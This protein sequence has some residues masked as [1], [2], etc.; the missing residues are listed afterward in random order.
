M[1]P[2]LKAAIAYGAEVSRE[3]TGATIADEEVFHQSKER[4]VVIARHATWAYLYSRNK[5]PK[6]DQIY[7]SYPVIARITAKRRVP[8]DHT[9]VIYG[10]RQFKKLNPEKWLALTEE[11]ADLFEDEAA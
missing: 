9:S 2:N 3:V 1:S 11:Q 7:Y 5:N 8:F 4:P 10:I 6:E